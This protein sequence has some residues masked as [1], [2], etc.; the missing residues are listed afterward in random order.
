MPVSVG[1]VPAI[2]PG[3]AVDVVV[4]VVAVPGSVNAVV[5]STFVSVIVELVSGGFVCSGL[6]IVDVV[7]V[8]V[9]SC[10]TS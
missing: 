7:P 8:V 10:T 9:P 1:N 4:A 5:V 2:V 3:G 6:S